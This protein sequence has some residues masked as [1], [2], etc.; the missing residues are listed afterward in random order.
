MRADHFGAALAGPLAAVVGV[1]GVL[2]ADRQGTGAD[3]FWMFV[4]IAGLL[5]HAAVALLAGW[6]GWARLSP[7]ALA[8]LALSSTV[9]GVYGFRSCADLPGAQACICEYVGA[10]KATRWLDPGSS[11]AHRANLSVACAADP[12]LPD[13]LKAL[14]VPR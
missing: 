5:T 12:A 11:E 13:A 1:A 6:T 2:V 10:V 8:V 4:A 3:L 7:V 14:P 9:V